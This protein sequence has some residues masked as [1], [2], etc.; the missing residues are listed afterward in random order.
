MIL[1]SGASSSSR[2]HLHNTSITSDTESPSAHHFRSDPNQISF[3]QLRIRLYG[4]S[5]TVKEPTFVISFSLLPAGILQTQSVVCLSSFQL[6]SL[7]D[8]AGS[9]LIRLLSSV[10]DT[11]AHFLLEIWTDDSYRQTVPAESSE[12]QKDGCPTTAAQFGL[13]QQSAFATS[14]TDILLCW[15]DLG[16]RPS[17]R[18]FLAPRSSSIAQTYTHLDPA[19]E[20]MSSNRLQI[21]Y[22]PSNVY[23]STPSRIINRHNSKKVAEPSFRKV[24]T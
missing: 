16:F 21:R 24:S 5:D 14:K 19:R 20:F 3:K 8:L 13:L 10:V 1:L 2:L 15:D 22:I 12:R 4:D 17:I 18:R 23:S 6:V 9:R 7:S 11:R